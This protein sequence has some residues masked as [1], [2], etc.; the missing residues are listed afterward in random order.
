MCWEMRARGPDLWLSINGD[1]SEEM[2]L[3]QGAEG[4]DG[5]VKR[6]ETGEEKKRLAK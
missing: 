2:A 1:T 3:N 6:E 5:D 4:P